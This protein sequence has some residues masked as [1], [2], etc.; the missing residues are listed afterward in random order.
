VGA[1]TD[2]L[3]VGYIPCGSPKNLISV[4]REAPFDTFGGTWVSDSFSGSSSSRE[5]GGLLQSVAMVWVS[6]PH[7]LSHLGLL[8][9]RK[10]ESSLLLLSTEHI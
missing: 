10:V 8:G 1:L 5:L 3:R 6:S 9:K 7:L 4:A 2:S